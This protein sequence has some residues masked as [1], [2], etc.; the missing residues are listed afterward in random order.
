[1]RLPFAAILVT[2][3]L[4]LLPAAA[5]AAGEDVVNDPAVATYMGIAA[6][7]WGQTPH[8][9]GPNGEQIAPYAIWGDNPN[10]FEGAW[11]EMPGCRIWLNRRQWPLP[12]NESQC[13]LIAHE[14]GHLLGLDHSPD[15]TN[16]MYGGEIPMVVPGCVQFREPDDLA[17]DP[18]PAPARPAKPKRLH[19]KK[20]KAPKRCAPARAKKH[21]RTVRKARKSCVTKHARRRQLRRR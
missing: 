14:W 1:M 15:P 4:A 17:D 13:N 6:G 12:P 10:P 21:R 18:T 5:R 2:C 7:F 3:A 20:R 16:L 8:C 11:A 9:T 19:L